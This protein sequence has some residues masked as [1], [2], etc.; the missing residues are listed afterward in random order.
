[1]IFFHYSFS[2]VYLFLTF[3]YSMSTYINGKTSIIYTEAKVTSTRP[4]PTMVLGSISMS[5]GILLAAWYHLNK[6]FRFSW[7]NE[8]MNSS[9]S[10]I[11]CCQYMYTCS[12]TGERKMCHYLLVKSTGFRGK[13][14]ARRGN[15]EEMGLFNLTLRSKIKLQLV[16]PGASV[17]FFTCQVT[18][19]C[20]STYHNLWLKL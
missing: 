6:S 2:F 15:E 13:R 10:A 17:P 9:I 3:L 5:Y 20:T 19:R 14:R 4:I 7:E 16:W 11:P 18:L 8:W 1:M 12:V